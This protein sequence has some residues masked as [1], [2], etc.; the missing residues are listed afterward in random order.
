[1]EDAPG[2]RKIMDDVNK[3]LR[4]AC[5]RN[6]E[7]QGSNVL[8]KVPLLKSA[9]G[10]TN[11][12]TKDPNQHSRIACADAIDTPA[13]NAAAAA[14]PTLAKIEGETPAKSSVGVLTI[15]PAALPATIASPAGKATPAVTA[16]APSQRAPP[17]IAAP[18][19]KK[20]IRKTPRREC[21]FPGCTKTIKS[22][23]HCQKH[24]ARAKRCK[25]DNCLKQAQGNYDGM[26]KSHWRE[27][28]DPRSSG[29]HNTKR[30]SIASADSI[31]SGSLPTTPVCRTADGSP[32]VAPFAVPASGDVM[33][34]PPAET[35]SSH[36]TLLQDQQPSETT[37]SNYFHER[38]LG[39][40]V[41]DKIIPSSVAWKSTKKRPA[42]AMPLATLLR[43]GSNLQP[44]WHRLSERAARGVRN[45]ANSQE[46]D[47]W[48]K[49]LVMI[50]ITLLAGT[51][52]FCQK[53][54]AHA[55]GRGKNFA[56]TLVS[57]VCERR[58]ELDRRK[59]AA[60]QASFTPTSPTTAKKTRKTLRNS[61]P[62]RPTSGGMPLP[63]PNSMLA[64][65][66]TTMHD[67]TV[68]SPLPTTLSTIGQPITDTIIKDPT[69]LPEHLASPPFPTVEAA[70]HDVDI[71]SLSTSA[72]DDIPIL[73]TAL[74]PRSEDT[75]SLHE[76]A[77]D[78]ILDLALETD[79]VVEDSIPITTT[80]QVVDGGLGG[81]T[82]QD[83]VVTATV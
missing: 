56:A 18:T 14:C 82:N 72:P 63:L 30:L 53:D 59:W 43:D 22:Q 28:N 69:T 60:E 57:Q 45:V 4:G 5:R 64:L 13:E 67:L 32:S 7:D 55:W 38:P 75:Q 19:Q 52:H 61:T 62:S 37:P 66:D 35:E 12:T 74:P 83:S 24:G 16:P 10:S 76:T 17:Q 6:E 70:P 20:K 36:T 1:M 25:V 68:A 65:Q 47:P 51:N 27:A 39:S 9:N 40:S 48:E 80:A 78:S 3:N 54:L 34:M 81:D 79:A 46:L 44:G 21:R 42:E 29:R 58:G 49:Q 77:T 41:Y 73:D 23:G 8:S 26:C 11:T 31:L 71:V 33:P 15:L 2:D 50:E